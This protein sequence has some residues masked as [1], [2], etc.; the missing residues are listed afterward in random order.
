MLFIYRVQG[1]QPMHGQILAF[2][3]HVTVA[4]S[5][6]SFV[7]PMVCMRNKANRSY[8]ENQD[9][10]CLVPR[11]KLGNEQKKKKRKRKKAIIIS[12][13]FSTKLELLNSNS[14][15]SNLI[16]QISNLTSSE[17]LTRKVPLVWFV[18]YVIVFLFKYSY[19]PFRYYNGFI[20]LGYVSEDWDLIG[21]FDT[22][23][24]FVCYNN[25]II[26]QHQRF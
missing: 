11:W 3:T 10:K 19:L 7:I 17:I 21:I 26:H 13:N 15:Y 20:I 5:I 8:K 14:W 4:L 2:V 12:L 1:C 22:I 24:H 23:Y 9:K 25:Q 18:I 6:F 16:K